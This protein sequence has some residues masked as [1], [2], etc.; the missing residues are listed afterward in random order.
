MLLKWL[1]HACFLLESNQP[2]VSVVTDPY[3]PGC[4]NG[5]LHYGPLNVTADVVTVSHSH[6]DHNAVAEVQG[7]PEVVQAPGK[8]QAKGV[9][10]EGFK[11]FHDKKQGAERG[12]DI[13]FCFELEGLAVCHLGDLGHVPSETELAALKPVDVLLIPVGGTFT[14]DAPEAD[15][16]I[17][18]LQPKLAVPMHFKTP[19]VDFPI[20]AV[21]P[22]LEGKEN[23]VRLERSY[24]ELPPAELPDS[25]QILVLKPDTC[26]E[27]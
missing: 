8:H 17:E 2:K 15:R 9:T 6:A 18:L 22:F 5:A 27:A 20:A 12:E 16:V 21:E 3:E 23:V 14:I 26:P 10:F 4:F 1:G 24:I 13:A 19:C 11:F 7:S 25:T